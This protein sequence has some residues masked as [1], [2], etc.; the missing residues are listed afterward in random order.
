[1]KVFV[2]TALYLSLLLGQGFMA[3]QHLPCCAVAAGKDAAAVSDD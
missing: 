3:G 2:L 1:M